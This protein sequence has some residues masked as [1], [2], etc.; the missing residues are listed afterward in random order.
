M[1][2]CGTPIRR[3][4]WISRGIWPKQRKRQVSAGSCSSVPSR[5]AAKCL[6][7]RPLRETDIE[8]P[9]DPYACSKWAAEQELRGFAERTGL[10]VVIVRPPLVYGPEVRANFLALLS[11]V[12]AG[13]PLPF[14]WLRNKRSLLYIDNFVSA[15]AACATHPR[16]AGETFH[17]SDAGSVTLPELVTELSRAM[18]KRPRI[19]P[20]PKSILRFASVAVGKGQQI[21]RLINE[22]EVDASKIHDM[23]GWSPSYSFQQGIQTTV[24]WYLRDIHRR[25]AAVKNGRARAAGTIKICQLCAVDFTLQHL[26]L[27]LVDGMREQRWSVT[28]V[29]SEGRYVHGHAPSRLSAVHGIHFAE[30]VQPAFPPASDLE[31]LQV[32]P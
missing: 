7:G 5:F 18:G 16:A 8:Q 15:L 25:N 26:L 30:P 1:R 29:C 17:V 28:S 3:R 24:N 21:E 23:L 13:L 10:E 20:L 32:M 11:A 6:N 14:S 31:Y 9:I 12:S 19:F 22:L 2:H 27:P 4:T